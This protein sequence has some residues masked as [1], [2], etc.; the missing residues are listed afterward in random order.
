[1]HLKLVLASQSPYRAMQLKQFGVSFTAHKPTVDE[2]A[3]KEIGPKEP[4][5]LTCFLAEQKALS[6]RSKFADHLILGSDQM[7]VLDKERLDKPGSREKAIHQLK[8][9]QG[10]T[11]RLITSLALSSPLKEQ[12]LWVTT[13]ITTVTMRPLTLSQIEAYLDMDQPYDCAGSYKIEKAGL[14]LI[15]RVEGQDPSAIQGLPLIGLTQGL[16]HL[17]YALNDFWE[18]NP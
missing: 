3:L 5:A 10:K 7:A 9:L 17:G 18:T 8:R 14:S 12:P 6:L 16:L 1:M 2:E 13:E 11:H 4:I 15:A